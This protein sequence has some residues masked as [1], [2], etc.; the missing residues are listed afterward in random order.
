MF[1][2]VVMWPQ[3]R[4]YSSTSHADH[5][6]LLGVDRPV[7]H[8][9]AHHLVVA[10]LALAVD[11]VAEPEDAEDVLVEV[12]REVAHEHLLELVDV[13]E[14]LGV[15][16]PRADGQGVGHRSIMTHLVGIYHTPP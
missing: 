11:A 15:D 13:R 2:R 8:L 3:P 14:L 12:A 1:W 5:L 16:R 7:R 10:A 6:E 4:E 9:D